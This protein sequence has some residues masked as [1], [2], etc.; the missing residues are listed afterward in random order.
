MTHWVILPVLLPLLG[1]FLQLLVRPFG[2][3]VQRLLGL[4]LATGLVA[5]AVWVLWLAQSGVTQVYNLGNWAAPFGIVLVLDRLSA[6]LVLL[7][8]VLALASLVYAV[9]MKV[10]ERGAHFHVLLQLQLFG[11]NGA[12]LTGDVFNLFVFFEVLLLAS[13]GLMLHGGGA[14]RVRAGLHYVVVNLVG[15][16]LFLFAV[17]ALY[18]A[19][20]T[21]NIADMAQKVAAAPAESH[22]LIA[23]A[24]LLLLL[25]FGLKAAMFPLYLWLPQ[26][27]AST[28]APVAA[29]FAI[30]TKVGVYAMVRVH[31]T[32]FSEQAGALAGVHLPW[33]LGGGLATLLLAALGVL[34]ARGL[35]EQVAYL[36]L[37]SVATLLV[38]VGL[39]SPD[40]LAAGLYYLLH[41]T[42][43]AAAFFLL[44]DLI[45]RRRGK[46]QDRFDAVCL[47]P[48]GKW[49]G[50]AFFAAAV[51][52]AGLPPLSGFI[53]K[54]LILDAALAHPWRWAVLAVVLSGSLLILV[55]LARSGSFLFYRPSPAVLEKPP[56]M[57]E[58]F[59]K[60]AL[61][62]ITA[63]LAAAP[64]LV[65]LAGPVTAFTGETVAQLQQVPAYIKAVMNNPL[66]GGE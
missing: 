57:P 16:T 52:L 54:I 38:A 47:M 30:M 6:M 42:L 25:V 40:A 48:G 32:V 39:A 28:S 24:G 35:R 2:L 23:G 9:M 49:L 58:P 13:Y 61:G 4:A 60:T 53:G 17:G 14:E 51:A 36:V 65:I 45:A 15:S 37:A 33:V 18:G 56:V 34:A 26:T 50:M 29:L 41:S 31:G 8:A 3:A 19:L 46:H 11:L 5:L 66:A 64:L 20:G 1:G 59:P 10:D 44:A 62:V 63:L 7:T 12:F 27:Y 55:A 21:L 43:L 22:G